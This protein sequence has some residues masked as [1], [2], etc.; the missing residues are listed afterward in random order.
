MNKTEACKVHIKRRFKERFGIDINRH[1]IRELVSNIQ[2][3]DNIIREQRLTN[4]V[5]AFDMNFK[6]NHCVVIYDKIRKVPVTVLTA[7]MDIQQEGFDW[8]I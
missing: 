6:N 5:T 4:R 7:D 2:S 8:R 3:G 1:D